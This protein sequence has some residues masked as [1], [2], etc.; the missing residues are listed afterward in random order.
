MSFSAWFTW[1]LADLE[2]LRQ[3]LL[4]PGAAGVGCK[5]SLADDCGVGREAHPQATLR[6]HQLL[7]FGYMES[8]GLVIYPRKIIGSRDLFLLLAIDYGKLRQLEASVLFEGEI[9]SL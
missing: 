4:Q 7:Q 9:D 6:N 2:H 1:I 3:W 8:S 5:C